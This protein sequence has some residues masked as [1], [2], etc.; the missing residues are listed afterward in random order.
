MT[1][2]KPTKTGECPVCHDRVKVKGRLICKHKHNST[3][4]YDFC[5]SGRGRWPVTG[6]VR[7]EA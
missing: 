2:K 6:T 3:H 5:R 1:P 4:T 7:E